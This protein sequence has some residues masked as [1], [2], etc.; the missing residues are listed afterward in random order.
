[1]LANELRSLFAF[2]RQ[3][4][5]G[6]PAQ[7]G[8]ADLALRIL[9]VICTNLLVIALIAWPLQLG[10]EK[11]LGLRD[12]IALPSLGMFFM[13]VCV[14]P[15]MEELIYRAGLRNAGFVL[16][17]QPI[18][19]SLFLGQWQVA[20]AL[21]CVLA[22]IGCVDMYRLKRLTPAQ[23]FALRMERGRAFLSRYRWIVWG[24]AIAF[25]LSH[26][27]NFAIPANTGWLS[28]LVVFAVVSQT[29]GGLV[30]S[31]L[32]LRYGLASAIIF[33]TSFNLMCFGLDRLSS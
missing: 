11:W 6:H 31:Y 22:L 26:V 4:R 32:R 20:L 18:L 28:L 29:W 9:L 5:R 21:V 3:P 13:G 1:M 8:A 16:A 24:Y 10:L 7:L 14:G 23:R 27:F 12:A 15:W 17:G 19:I 2:L 33:H 30:M 25:G